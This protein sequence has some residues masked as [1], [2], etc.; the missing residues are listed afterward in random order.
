MFVER[1]PDSRVADLEMQPRGSVG[2]G[3]LANFEHHVAARSELDGIADEVGQDLLE[4]DR[5][6]GDSGGD[7]GV[8]VE[9]ELQ[10][11]LLRLQSQRL[12]QG[13]HQIADRERDGFELQLAR[14]D[15]REVQDVV[16]DRQQGIGRRLDGDEVIALLRRQLGVEGEL[17]HAD[18]AVHGCAD[19]VAHVGEELALG[20]A[21]F[22]RLVARRDEI[23]VRGAQL[24]GANLDRLLELLLVP[25][26]LPVPLLNLAEHLVEP[27]HQ[28]AD[29]VAAALL[30]PQIV[31]VVA[32]H[33]A[34]DLGEPQQWRGN[35]PLQKPP[36]D[37]CDADCTDQREGD[38]S[39][40]PD[41]ALSHFREVGFDDHH[42]DHIVLERDRPGHEQVVAAERMPRFLPAQDV[43]AHRGRRRHSIEIPVVAGEERAVEQEDGGR[44]DVCVDRNG[45][46]RF[47]GAAGITERDRRGAVVADDMGQE[48]NVA[49]EPL[50]RARDVVSHD[51]RAGDDHGR[52]AGRHTDRGQ[53][54]RQR[55]VP[56]P[57]IKAGHRVGP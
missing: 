51:Q 28:L 13:A 8:D 27:A 3:I 47:A 26:E 4:T 22:H 49:A 17:C 11:F 44:R 19:L 24:R 32:G 2:A 10:P 5:I 56:E 57:L 54:F 25:L 42:A 38:D 36:D 29:L 37:E 9:Q 52:G 48:A 14:L 41:R 21:R 39:P 6:A 12:E 40:E 16:E 43:D 18:D 15:L 55:K 7:C 50:T 33:D 45:A 1:D 20:P 30:D 53:F 35:H 46:E 31:P 23:R 34:R